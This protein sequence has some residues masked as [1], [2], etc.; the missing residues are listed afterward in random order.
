MLM[1]GPEAAASLRRVA[2]VIETL[3]QFPRVKS[4]SGP[5]PEEHQIGAAVIVA[6]LRDL[7]TITPKE[8]FTRCEILVALNEMQND[9][10]IFTLD[11][12]E[13]FD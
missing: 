6:H 12:L 8:Q 13:L 11:L 7:F 2:D 1:T 9:P 5:L 10:N 4:D 3:D